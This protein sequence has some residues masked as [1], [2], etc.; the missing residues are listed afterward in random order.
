MMLSVEE[1]EEILKLKMSMSARITR[2]LFMLCCDHKYTKSAVFPSNTVTPVL[3]KS[4]TECG[5]TKFK[6]A[7]F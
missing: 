5:K 2:F 4:C 1:C 7:N 6:T 3:V